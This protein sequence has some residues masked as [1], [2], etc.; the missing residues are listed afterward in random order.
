MVKQGENRRQVEELWQGQAE[1]RRGLA[2]SRQCKKYSCSAAVLN[3]SCVKAVQIFLQRHGAKLFL[4]QG[5]ANVPVSRRCKYSCVK[6][7]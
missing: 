1:L 7:V 2:K 3:Y 5:G 6:A 4:C